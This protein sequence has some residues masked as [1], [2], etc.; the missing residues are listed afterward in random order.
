M[1]KIKMKDKGWGC[2]RIRHVPLCEIQKL[3]PD[4]FVVHSLFLTQGVFI[5]N[6]APAVTAS[7]PAI[8]PLIKVD[9]FYNLVAIRFRE[10]TRH[11]WT[12]CAVVSHFSTSQ[13]PI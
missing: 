2:P 5:F 7:L 9:D 13:Q 8:L 6:V 4:K 11:N 12:M 10:R 3:L 1:L